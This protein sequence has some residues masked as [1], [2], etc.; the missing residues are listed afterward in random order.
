MR[1][2]LSLERE[3]RQALKREGSKE[4]LRLVTK[5]YQMA[6]S[7][8]QAKKSLLQAKNLNLIGVKTTARQN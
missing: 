5:K 3:H 2:V 8:R 6:E 1:R 7:V 4:Q